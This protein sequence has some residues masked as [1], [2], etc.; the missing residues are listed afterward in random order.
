[1]KIHKLK[2]LEMFADD[3]LVGRKNFEI[4]YNDNNYAI[5]EY[6]QFEVMSNKPHELNKKLY[7]ITCVISGW[8]LIEGFVALGIREVQR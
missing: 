1:M 4:R 3:V 7:K 8:G 5:G 2:L 6:I